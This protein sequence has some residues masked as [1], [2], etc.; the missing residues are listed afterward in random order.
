MTKRSIMNDKDLL[1][2]ADAIAADLQGPKGRRLKL[3]KVIDEHLDWFDQARR[4]G[5]EWNDI[6]G[7]LFSA[8][9]T[10]NDGRPLARAHV[11]SLVWRKQHAERGSCPIAWCS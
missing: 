7:L 3:A 6:V 8:G 1:E 10:R 9:A 11:Q 2:G 4:R 5:L